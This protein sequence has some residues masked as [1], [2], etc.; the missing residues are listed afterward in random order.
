M[1]LGPYSLNEIYTGE[2]SEA[3]AQLP[4]ACIDLT[5]TSPPYD[6][7]RKYNGYVFPFEEIAGQLYRVTKL[8]GVVV[9]VVGDATING[10]ESGNS[11]RQA[12]YFMG[13]GFNLLDTMIYQK[14]STGA[15]GTK[16]AYWQTFDYMFVFCKG[17]PKR[18]QLI[19]DV[20]FVGKQKMFEA[21]R[22]DIS[23]NTKKRYRRNYPKD[24]L[25]RRG[26]VWKISN[27]V[28]QH[29]TTGHPAPF[30]EALALDH[31]LSWSNPGD[32]VLDPM[33][34][35]GTVAKM[36]KEAGRQWLGFDISQEYV[37]MARRRVLLAQPPLFVAMPEQAVTSL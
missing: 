17:I 11:F 24:G 6:N 18:G 10:S 25:S 1:E 9:W 23:G 34:G 33:M 31:I 14:P 12:L 2:C 37:I 26:N 35:G 28:N 20:P 8:G 13:L 36:A 7:L 3:M 5:V 19:Q 15:C 4:D 21:G 27:G 30:P 16:Y 29:I 22:K 32:L